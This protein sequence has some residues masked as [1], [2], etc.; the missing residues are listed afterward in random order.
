[1]KPLEL[2]NKYLE[3]FYSGKNIQDVSHLFTDDL[4]FTGP[5]YSFDTS[6]AYINSLLSNP[7]ENFKYSIL[8]SYENATSTCIIYQF[9]KPGI[10][11]PMTQYFEI[12]SGKINKI[13]LIFDTGKFT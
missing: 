10:T 9:S 4:K 6:E 7:P 1:M 8:H 12:K 5:F 2:A 13:L 11:L 3:I